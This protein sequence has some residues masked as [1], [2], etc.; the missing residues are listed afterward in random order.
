MEIIDINIS[1]VRYDGPYIKKGKH[2]RRCRFCNRL[3]EDGEIV[4]I[5]ESDRGY[6]RHFWH[7]G[8]HD[9]KEG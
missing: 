6:K 2:R 4:V 3:I 5:E 8:C 9:H 1:P 7:K